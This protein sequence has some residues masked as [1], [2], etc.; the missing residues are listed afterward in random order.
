MGN[1]KAV[2]MLLKRMPD[3]PTALRNKIVKAVVKIIGGKSLTLLSDEE[4][5]RFRQY[6][7]VALQDEDEEIQDAAIQGLAYVGGEEASRGILRIAAALDPDRD[8]DRL[9]LIIG[10]LS[11][12]GLTEALKGGLLGEDQEQARVAVQV[13]AQIAP[14]ECTLEDCVCQVLMEAFWKAALPVQ[15]QIV[16]VV[17]SKSDEQSK[18]FFIRVLNEHEDGTVLKSAVYLLGEKLRLAEVV[19]RIFPLLDHQYDDVKEAALEA[20]IAIGGDGVQARFQEMFTSEEPV[21]RLMATYALG[22][23]G[24]MENLEILRQ[25]VEDVVPD[26][27]KV[28]VEALAASGGDDSVW[29]PLVLHRLSDESKDVRLTVIEIMGHHYDQEMVP[30]LLDALDD[31]DDWVKIRAMDALGEHS[32]AEA[33]PRMVEMLGNTNRFVVMKAI[34]ALGNI[35]GSAAFAA[36]LEVTNSDEYE[37][38]SAAEEAISKIQEM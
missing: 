26:I 9:A 25:A 14:D 30:H 31:E 21:H 12:I 22:K 23:L 35:G 16:G 38:V 6:L 17:A 4:R 27:R 2:T 10:F 15:R 20:C 24:P 32:T 18:D 19:D 5:E 8:Q 33:A 13:L 11:Q 34:E 36:L 3:A 1:V 29:R 37:L 7:L 28:A